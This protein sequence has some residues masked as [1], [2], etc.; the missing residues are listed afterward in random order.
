MAYLDS[1]KEHKD[2]SSA[3]SGDTI[4]L[5]YTTLVEFV[6]QVLHRSIVYSEQVARLKANFKVWHKG[7][8]EVHMAPIHSLCNGLMNLQV[9]NASTIEQALQLMGA[10]H[11]LKE[12]PLDKF[13]D[14]ENDG[15]EGDE[16]DFSDGDIEASDAQIPSDEETRNERESLFA[17]RDMRPPAVRLP[18]RFF[19]PSQQEE[20]VAADTDEEEEEDLVAELEEEA[21]IDHAD[22]KRSE[23]HEKDLWALGVQ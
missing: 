21:K 20:L 14:S 18:A 10:S 22:L 7:D 4:R 5:L 12:K 8:K 13:I 23:E 9:I 19:D 2:I 16:G 15:E 17:F 11:L 1:E 6:T 3:I